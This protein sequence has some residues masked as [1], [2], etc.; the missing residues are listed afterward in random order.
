V[1]A[2]VVRRPRPSISRPTALALVV[3]LLIA[4]L[5]YW[6]VVLGHRSAM[7]GDVNDFAVP[8]YV[9]VWRA[10]AAGHAPWWT[11]GVFAGHSM[12]GAGQYAVFYPFNV[13]FALLSPVT[14]YRWWLI[15]HIW[16]AT[17][18]A[19]AWSYHRF[20]SRAGAVISGV[21]YSGSGFAVFHLVHPPWVIAVAW[22]PVLMLGVDMVSER[23]SVRRGALPA[24]ALALIA[25]GG[26]PQAV[27]LALAAVGVYVA[28]LTALDRFD[29]RR[30][31]RVAGALAVGLGV[32]AVQLLPLWYFSRTSARPALSAAAAF[33]DSLKPHDLPTL[34]FPWMYGGSSQ[35]S[36][37][38]AAW[39]AGDLQHEV[40][41][42][43]G[44]SIVALALVALIRL[45]RRPAILAL[46]AVG[47]FSVLFAL[48]G[49]TP[50][51]RVFYEV[52]PFARSFRGWA[53]AMLLLNLA[54]AMLAGAGVREVARAPRQVLPGLAGAAGALAIVSL[55][56]P[57]VGAVQRFLVGGPYGI[58]ARGAPIVILVALVGAVA[59]T[60]LY[61]RA[62][63]CALIA[64][65]SLDI[66]AFAYAAEWRGQSSPIHELNAFYDESVSPPF[67]RAYDAPG[68]VDRWATDTYGFRMVSLAKNLRGVNGYDPL[69]QREW[70]DTA[71]GFAYDGNPTRPDFWRPGWLSD[72]LRVST[73]VLNNT[74]TPTDPGWQKTS[75]VPGYDMSRWERAPRL[76][77]AYLVRRVRVTSLALIRQALVDP[78]T[79]ME[80]TAFVE[81]GSGDVVRLDD[82]R[83]AG[84]V[85]SADVLGSGR[86][87]VD[88]DRRSLLVLSHDWEA[89]WHATV[90]GHTT[91]VMRTN[92]LVLGIVVPPG[93]HVVRVGF[94]PPGLSSGAL[95]CFLALA[96]LLT[97]VPL[98]RR[99]RAIGPT[100]DGMPRHPPRSDSAATPGG[101]TADAEVGEVQRVGAR[102][103]GDLGGRGEPEGRPDLTVHDQDRGP[104]SDHE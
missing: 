25:F 73:L 88:A 1:S 21:A 47:V 58:I 17:G 76:P 64:I 10:I 57:H 75:A 3:A 60:A 87:V 6:E 11:P 72:V 48:G 80:N 93:H 62:G 69:I 23:W 13:L 16:A 12:L 52:L 27:W 9:S 20:R 77:E 46:G 103:H 53:R 79:P 54:L 65:C 15:F 37:F 30:V 89:G 24:A 44:A 19:F 96:G 26:H 35:G 66:F 31:V 49:S 51:G 70:A 84:S 28:A 18:G 34:V 59:V 8:A 39:R 50:L 91:P 86:V 55:A 38:S 40:G 56:L 63:V 5:P 14:A 7:Y 61:P 101:S 68:G 104:P 83:P 85:R 32:G 98:G 22:L 90:D 82:S 36:V 29:L 33:Q 71:G 74:V 100:H 94:G 43:A 92:G 4:T 95:V 102:R 81:S 97:A 67:G 41:M 45:R 42:F 2:V 99:L 78:L